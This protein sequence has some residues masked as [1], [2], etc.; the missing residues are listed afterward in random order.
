MLVFENVSGVLNDTKLQM[1]LFVFTPT[2]APWQELGGGGGG[3][4]DVAILG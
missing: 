4:G 1:C 3:V 2:I